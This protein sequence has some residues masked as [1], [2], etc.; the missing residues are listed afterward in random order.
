MP[1]ITA[2]GVPLLTG[3]LEGIGAKTN[4]QFVNNLFNPVNMVPGYKSAEKYVGNK[5]KNIPTSI[6]PE[7]RQGVEPIDWDIFNKKIDPRIDEYMRKANLQSSTSKEANSVLSDFKERIKTS[8]GIRRAK[9]LGADT[10]YLDKLKLLE[11]NTTYGYSEGQNIGL[12]KNLPKEVIKS[13]TRHEIEHGVKNAIQE[14][15]MKKAGKWYKNLPFMNNSAEKMKALNT[16]TTPIDDILLELELRNQPSV[17]DEL[18]K[19]DKFPKE[20][21][22]VSDFKEKISNRQAATDYFDRGSQGN[23]KSAFAAEAQQYM[24]DEGIIKH[25]YENITPEKIKEAHAKALFDKKNPIR[26]FH[27]MKNTDKNYNTVAKALNKVLTVTGVG[28]LGAAAIEQK[29][30]GG[31]IKDDRGQWGEHKGEPTRINQSKPGSY[32]D[33]GPDP[34]TGEPL[35]EP[36][37]G[38]SDKGEKKIMYPGEKHKYKKGT[39]YV[40][41]FPIAKNGLRQEQKGLQNLEDLTNFTNYNKPSNWL[42]KYN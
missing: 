22:D 18:A 33:M 3:G 35:T 4:R 32:I 36:L 8:E 37:L 29:R 30:E 7:L 19:K 13:V 42:N 2:I 31:I 6:A 1:L 34:L 11:D 28:A 40:D 41:E 23:E 10:D 27:I 38:I 9:E 17:F 21:I 25:P 16:N 20:N 14:S 26:L 24:L 5:L 39:K 15:N 12:H